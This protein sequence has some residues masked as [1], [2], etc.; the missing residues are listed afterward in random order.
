MY[1]TGDV[2]YKFPTD[3]QSS[4]QYRCLAHISSIVDR[5]FLDKDFETRSIN[6]GR[7]CQQKN[8]FFLFLS[9]SGIYLPIGLYRLYTVFGDCFITRTLFDIY[10]TVL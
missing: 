10:V 3:H 9:N 7:S 4:F 5:Y 8:V 2:E 1:N 6:I